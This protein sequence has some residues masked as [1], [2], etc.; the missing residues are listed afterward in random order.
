MSE[1]VTL[2]SAGVT[3]RLVNPFFNGISEAG[4]QLVKRFRLPG[5]VKRSRVPASQYGTAEDLNEP[6]EHSAGASGSFS[7]QL[8]FASRMWPF[9]SIFH[10]SRWPSQKPSRFEGTKRLV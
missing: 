4:T 8:P 5:D 7:A 9:V 6:S 3:R 10:D 1:V 2:M